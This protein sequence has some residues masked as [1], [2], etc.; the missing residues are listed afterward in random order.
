MDER[1]LSWRRYNLGTEL[2]RF[3]I[4]KLTS[5]NTIQ[6]GV[7]GGLVAYVLSHDNEQSWVR[8][9]LLLP[10]VL[11]LGQ[12]VAIWRGFTPL[13]RLED[14]LRMAA[15]GLGPPTA[16]PTVRPLRTMM[17]VFFFLNLITLIGLVLIVGWA[18]S[19]GLF[20]PR[21]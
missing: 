1:E 11:C 8:G 10:A 5:L 6:L 7:T 13:R 21:I 9:A 19:L 2:Y 20:P 18:R 3:Y 12:C 14:D 4:D 16:A 17:R 15:L